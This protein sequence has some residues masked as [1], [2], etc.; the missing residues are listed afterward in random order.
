MLGILII[1][2]DPIYSFG[3]VS[4]K[5]YIL[6]SCSTRRKAAVFFDNKLNSVTK[7]DEP[8]L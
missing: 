6:V 3:G 1:L 8:V 5:H 4:V 7:L 2:N